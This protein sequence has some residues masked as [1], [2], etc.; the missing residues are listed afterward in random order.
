[1]DEVFKLNKIRRINEL[2]KQ[3]ISLLETKCGILYN[4]IKKYEEKYGTEIAGGHSIDEIINN[5]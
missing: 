2:Q 1:M 5:K 4:I 3:Q